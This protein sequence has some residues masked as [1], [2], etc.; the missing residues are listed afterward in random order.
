MR[1]KN[2]P[3]SGHSKESV[4]WAGAGPHFGKAQLPVFVMFALV[5]VAQFLTN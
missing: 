1:P 4:R 5:L 3:F 2:L